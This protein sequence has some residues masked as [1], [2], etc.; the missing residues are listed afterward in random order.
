M[1]NSNLKKLRNK[2]DQIDDQILDLL[3]NRA[4]VVLE[5]GK[6]KAGESREFYVPSRE[7]AIFER[8]QGGNP[9]PFPNESICRVFREIISASLS[10]E[11]PMKV[12]YLG[13]Q[14]TFTHVA[15]MEQFGL[16]AQLVPQKSIPA[17]F[18]E[19]ER[20]RAHYGVVPV[21]NSTEGVVNHTLDMFISSELQVIAEILLE[22]SHDLLSQT[23]KLEQ[24]CKVVSHPQALAQCRRWLDEN[25]PD[26]PQMDLT[27]TAAAAQMAAE[28]DTVA[29]IASQAAAR[30]Y[31]LQVA[32]GKIEDN[33]NNFTRFLVI[34][35]K[36]P[37]P[38]GRDKTSI[39]FS[40]HDEPGILYRMLEPF[41]KRDINLVKIESRPMKQ[42][43]WEYIFFLDL[44]GHV[45]DEKISAAIE[46]LRSHCH[47]L[48]ILGSYPFA[49]QGERE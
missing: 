49:G 45:E 31:G 26:T 18:E 14:S 5:V 48:K 39:M 40:V 13:P 23:G 27:S 34:G 19:V 43:A 8:L 12:A 41:S 16:S 28:D 9:G 33:P 1:S 38:S 3:N 11:M 42:K 10:L 46:D 15:A 22:I 36:R 37:D 2:I 4:R 35:S 32:K 25:L 29:A 17:V 20:G 7:R 21:E 24:I 6:A 30:Q 44:V 47:F